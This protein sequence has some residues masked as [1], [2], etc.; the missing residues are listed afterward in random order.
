MSV[1]ELVDREVQIAL[2]T[3]LVR[4]YT[5]HGGRFGRLLTAVGRFIRSETAR[6]EGVGLVLIGP[7]TIPVGIAQRGAV[8]GGRRAGTLVV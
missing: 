4:G 1:L 3:Q 6:A 2:L 8:A 7:A 5:V